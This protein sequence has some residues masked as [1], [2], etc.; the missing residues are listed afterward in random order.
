MKKLTTDL[1]QLHQGV[2]WRISVVPFVLSGELKELGLVA[3]GVGILR[4]DGIGDCVVLNRLTARRI[5]IRVRSY[6][7][8]KR[9]SR[10]NVRPNHVV[11]FQ[12]YADSSDIQRGSRDDCTLPAER[13]NWETKGLSFVPPENMNSNSSC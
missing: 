2:S 13:R 5:G 10:L 6:R 1:L 4:D 11:S 12:V 8:V 9:F 7:T 3:V